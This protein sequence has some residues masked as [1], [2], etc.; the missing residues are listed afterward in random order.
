MPEGQSLLDEQ[1]ITVGAL[2]RHKVAPSV[3]ALQQQSAFPLQVTQDAQLLVG[4]VLAQMPLEQTWPVMQARPVPQRHTPPEQLSALLWQAGPVPQWHV[5]LL[6]VSPV[7]QAGPVPQWHVPLLQ[8]S[9]V[10]QTGPLPQW[11]TPPEQVSALLWQAL[12][13]P[14]QLFR[15]VLRLA[16]QPLPGR[17]SQLA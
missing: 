10:L 17:P 16:S 1:P 9:P 8:V 4:H 13:Q 7:L 11:H 5:P 2:C 14:P 3:V 15:S 6:Q 12:P